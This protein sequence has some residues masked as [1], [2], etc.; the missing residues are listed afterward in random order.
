MG[1]YNKFE[2]RQAKPRP[3]EIHPVWRGIGCIMML[4]IPVLSYAGAVLLYDQNRTAHWVKIP[5]ELVQSI[6]IPFV[7]SV[8]HLF[9]NLIGAVLLMLIGYA[10]FMVFYAL[11]FRIIGP[12]R[13]GP[14]DS[15]PLRR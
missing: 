7:G 10:I 8:P 2:S 11:I 14:I 9:A 15:P 3:W 4:I 6:S 1:K 5:R 13:Y 12:P